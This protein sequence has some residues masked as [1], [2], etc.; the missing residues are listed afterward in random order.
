MYCVVFE[1]RACK[2]DYPTGRLLDERTLSRLMSV[3]KQK[4]TADLILCRC[5]PITLNAFLMVQIVSL[6]HSL[7]WC[8][9]VSLGEKDMNSGWVVCVK[10]PAC[11]FEMPVGGLICICT[12]ACVHVFFFFLFIYAH[13]TV[14]VQKIKKLKCVSCEFQL[15]A[16][17]PC[18]HT[19]G[20]KNSNQSNVFIPGVLEIHSEWPWMSTIERFMIFAVH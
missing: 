2:V 18:I 11:V 17:G 6:E 4:E 12:G 20:P 7:L 3:N 5:N 16:A 14:C 19:L 13:V 10:M 8:V 1:L 9:C 15:S